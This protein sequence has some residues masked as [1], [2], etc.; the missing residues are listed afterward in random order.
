MNKDVE[1]ILVSEKEIDAITDRLAD[2]IY[3]DYKDTG[4][5]LL[6]LM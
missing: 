1:S 5:K 6:L 2:Q 4:K 3:H